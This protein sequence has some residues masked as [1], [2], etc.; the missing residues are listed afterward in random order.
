MQRDQ[1]IVRFVVV[2]LSD[3]NTMTQFPENLCPTQR[4]DSVAGA[5]S[6]W[7]RSDYA[8]FHS[9]KLQR[10]SAKSG[11]HVAAA[12]MAEGSVSDVNQTRTRRAA[13]AAQNFVIT[14]P[15]R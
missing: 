11:P 4:R 7:S 2:L 6:F 5:R 1:Q 9:F 12:T 8:D 14:K 15:R 10:A 13:T 3:Q